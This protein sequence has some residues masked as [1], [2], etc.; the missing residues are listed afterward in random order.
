MRKAL[1]AGKSARA[2]LYRL[3]RTNA[4]LSA[5]LPLSMGRNGRGLHFGNGIDEK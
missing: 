2:A 3:R 1:D 5:L 4:D